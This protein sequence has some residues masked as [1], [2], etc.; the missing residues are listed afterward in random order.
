MGSFQVPQGD[1]AGL[2]AAASQFRRLAGHHSALAASLAH[3][4]QQAEDGWK[5]G[6]AD[7]F[8]Q[9]AQAVHTR[10]QPVSQAAM[11]ASR[12]LT[13]YAAALESAQHTV[14]SLNN[15]ADTISRQQHIEPADR[16]QVMSQLGQQAGTAASSVN[17]AARVCA[18]RIAAAQGILGGALPDTMSLQQL[19]DEVRRASAELEKEDPSLWE[20]IFGPDGMLRTWDERLHA[21]PAP[22]ADMVLIKLLHSAESAHGAAED[23]AEFAEKIPDLMEADF[24]NRVLP[25]MQDMSRGE[26]TFAD[27]VDELRNFTSDWSAV[28]DVNSAFQAA[29]EA[30][31]ARLPFLRGAGIGLGV[32]AMVGDAYTIAKPE[33]SGVMGHVDQGAAVLNLGLTGADTGMAI[34]GLFGAEASMP[35]AG[36]VLMVGTGLFLGGDW[37]Y[38]HIK[39]FH[40]FCNTVGHA[41]VSVAK[42]AW[43]AITSIF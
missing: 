4:A 30:E 18:A 1:P 36:E 26:A 7:R 39:P 38:H 33:D 5:G 10:F 9:C 34:A 12:E 31:A 25:V 37:A 29:N 14:S 23:A 2:R 19:Q 20:K 24:P 13:T 15:Q 43:H 11:A 35:V 3:H 8:R 16:A 41:A 27:L 22:F 21:L 32:M 17:Q 42:H 28:E 40:D 6:F